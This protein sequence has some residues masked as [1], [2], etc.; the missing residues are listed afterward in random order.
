MK[1][2]Q[3]QWVGRLLL[4]VVDLMNQMVVVVNSPGGAVTAEGLVVKQWNN[5]FIPKGTGISQLQEWMMDKKKAGMLVGLSYMNVQL[6][7]VLM[8]T[9]GVANG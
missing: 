7:L 1:K 5:V 6:Q 4:L 3:L 8:L 2:L 9:D